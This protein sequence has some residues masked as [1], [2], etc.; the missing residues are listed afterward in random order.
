M[1]ILDFYKK[2]KKRNNILMVAFVVI[3][4]LHSFL[5][6]PAISLIRRV[7]GL[8]EKIQPI[9]SALANQDL[10][11]LG[12]E[13]AYF[14]EEL[15]LINKDVSRMNALSFLPII[16]SYIKDAKT[17]SSLSLDLLDTSGNLLLAIGNSVPNLTFKGWGAIDDIFT[18]GSLSEL[19]T[20]TATLSEELPNY[21]KNFFLIDKKMEEIDISKYPEEFRGIR[22]K[23]MFKDLK[24]VTS[25]MSE[26]FDDVVEFLN[27]VPDLAGAK[28]KPKSYLVF[29]Q[30][31]KE[32]RPSG[33]VLSAYSVF[34][35]GAGGLQMTKSGDALL[36]D[37]PG[38]GVR[39]AAPVDYIKNYTGASSFY[40]RDAN[41]SPDYKVSATKINEIWSKIPGTFPVDGII[42]L[43]TH[44][45]AALV[46]LVDGLSI[47]NFGD[48]TSKNVVEQLE[49]FF[50]ATG[51]HSEGVM[52]QKDLTGAILYELLGK[53]FSSDNRKRMELLK[54]MKREVEEKHILF[55]FKDSDIQKIVEKYNG[56]GR[57]RNYEGDYLYVSEANVGNDKSNWY[58]TREVI[59]DIDLSKSPST[60]NIK[61]K[62]NNS[63]KYNDLFNRS[64]KA[65]IRVYV[66]D[67]SELIDSSGSLSKVE[68]GSDLE[69]TY[70]GLLIEVK[71]ESET[72]VS[73]SYKLPQSL[74]TD[75]KNYN[76]MIQKQPGIDKIPY[77]IFV[78]SERKE[79]LELL[80]D[81][82]LTISL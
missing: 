42:V 78:N 12:F 70:F 10:E 6:A 49:N 52:K 35:V 50:V 51:S 29:L 61:V 34:T 37:A 14:R 9:K 76:L 32:L 64:Y 60:S 74:F 79:D 11:L 77:E 36:I 19:T 27:L 3:V 46:E 69:K 17:V 48:V 24:L 7:R 20:L 75:D 66:P 59:K 15:E 5:F 26:S 22:I 16:G 81:T 18:E 82:E 53:T 57:V 65:Y 73:L 39:Y 62:Y 38:K 4:F 1:N 2:N 68:V 58:I 41:F 67:G 54:V 47:A 33:G 13:F 80:S 44:F 21:K 25:L 43:D 28:G 72:E 63:G 8:P 56:A 31:D 45:I 55:Y 23:E 71:P 40:M 30:N